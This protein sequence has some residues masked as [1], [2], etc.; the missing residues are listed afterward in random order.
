[1][2]C[3]MIMYA[4]LMSWKGSISIFALCLL[5]ESCCHGGIAGETSGNETIVFKSSF[6]PTPESKQTGS[7]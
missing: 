4:I 6:P 1:M 2:I 7:N 5:F 3:F